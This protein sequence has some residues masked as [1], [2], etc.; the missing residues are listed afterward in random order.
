LARDRKPKATLDQVQNG[1]FKTQTLRRERRA[2]AENAENPRNLRMLYRYTKDMLF[3][4]ATV[5]AS[6]DRTN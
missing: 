5:A 1:E 4:L 2:G 6:E 3:R